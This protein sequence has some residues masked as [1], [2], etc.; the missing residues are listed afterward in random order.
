MGIKDLM[1]LLKTYCTPGSI[2]V[3]PGEVREELASKN[4]ASEHV[5]ADINPEVP[6]SVF[7]GHRIAIDILSVFHPQ[8]VTAYDD[9]IKRS[10]NTIPNDYDITTVALARFA[11]TIATFIFAKSIPVCVMDGR[12]TKLKSKTQIARRKVAENYANQQVDAEIRLEQ[13]EKELAKPKPEP[14]TEEEHQQH[15]E[16]LIV[17]ASEKVELTKRVATAMKGSVRVSEED[18]QRIRQLVI[19][20]GIPYIIAP[21]EAEKY[22]AQLTR[23]GHCRAALSQDTDLF[24]HGCPVIIRQLKGNIARVCILDN[25]LRQLN[26]SYESFV[27][28]CVMCGTDYNP[29]VRGFG[30][31]R[32][33]RLIK[34]YGSLEAMP[35]VT[36]L[37]IPMGKGSRKMEYK[38][39]LLYN[40]EEKLDWQHIRREFLEKRFRVDPESLD[41]DE[42]N[43]PLV[44]ELLNDSNIL[45]R[46][47]KA[48]SDLMMQEERKIPFVEYF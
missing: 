36:I 11:R 47:G 41:L 32:C 28:L 22:C 30:Y 13:L 14:K 48:H 17:A 19:A 5:V 46:Y 4:R 7:E 37:D 35:E 21:E 2:G 16:E 12:A 10:P 34:Q 3:L 9:H 42:C 44:R 26:L 43:M 27:D 18:K 38:K 24:A 31:E 25:V 39:S 33:Y 15:A 45:L 6:L 40:E 29:N 23:E 8:K 20:M 1:D